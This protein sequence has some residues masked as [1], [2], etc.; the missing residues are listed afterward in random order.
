MEQETYPSEKIE[1]QFHTQEI[2][3]EEV[4][5]EE[6]IG[7]DHSAN[8]VDTE[9]SRGEDIGSKIGGHENIVPR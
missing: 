9:N 8:I 4:D 7:A 1:P 6:L 3:V 2:N 5:S